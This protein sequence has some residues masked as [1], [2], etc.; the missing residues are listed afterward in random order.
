MSIETMSNT[1][2]KNIKYLREKNALTIDVMAAML[3]ISVR[4]LRKIEE[5][6]IPPSVNIY[7]L[8]HSY[9]GFGVT[10]HDLLYTDMEA[11]DSL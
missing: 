2:C 8:W 11:T 7:I 1:F 9:T 4:N 10:I 3:G 6:T 5:G